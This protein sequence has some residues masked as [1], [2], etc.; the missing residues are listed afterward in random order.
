MA[1]TGL[2]SV[3]GARPDEQQLLAYFHGRIG[4]DDLLALLEERAKNGVGGGTVDDPSVDLQNYLIREFV[5]SLYGLEE[6]L[7][8]ALYSP[9]ALE[10]ALLGDFSPVALAERVLTALRSGRRSATAATFQFAEL[11]R[12]V[13]ALPIDTNE[14]EKLALAE[15]VQRAVDRLLSFVGQAAGIP[16]IVGVLRDSH[17]TDYVRASLPKVFAVRFLGVLKDQGQALKKGGSDGP[18][19]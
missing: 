2:P 8:L 13:A 16:S 1:K 5:E 12:V 6:T 15:V 11:V 19:A 9:R 3:L 18:A 17:F 10:T 7:K 14:T 4:E